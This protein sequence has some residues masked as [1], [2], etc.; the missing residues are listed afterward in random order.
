M[1]CL[2]LCSDFDVLL[3][4]GLQVFGRADENAAMLDLV[5]RHRQQAQLAACQTSVGLPQRVAVRSHA[6]DLSFHRPKQKISPL[7]A[8]LESD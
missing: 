7:V 8:H 2:R 6:L 3:G 4:W 5:S 1:V